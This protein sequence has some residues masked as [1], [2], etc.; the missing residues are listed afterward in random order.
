[1]SNVRTDVESRL[2]ASVSTVTEVDSGV[3]NVYIVELDSGCTVVVKYGTF[4]SASVQAEPDVMDMVRDTVSISIPGILCNA[5]TEDPPFYIMEYFEGGQPVHAHELSLDTACE[6]AELLGVTLGEMQ[7]NVVDSPGQFLLTDTGVEPIGVDTFEDEFR[8]ILGQFATQARHNYDGIVF[9]EFNI[10][11]PETDTLTYCP[12]DLHT[13][14]L[15][16]DGSDVVGL[17]DFERVYSGHPRWGYENTLYMLTVTRS[18]EE[19]AQIETA[20]ERGYSSM[21]DVP[22][23]SPVFELAAVLREM[24]ATHIWWDNPEDHE[25]RLRAR[26]NELV[27][28][29]G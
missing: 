11:V 23:Y 3:N 8:F 29:Y 4:D 20:F 18:D 19:A 27:G 21:R 9:D 10:P 13:K 5:S 22:E 17:I 6:L 26:F 2:D 25:E 14:N 15:V 24:R 1:M 12:L 7:R 16:L 28:S